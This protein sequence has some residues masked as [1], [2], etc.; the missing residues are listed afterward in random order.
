ML[1]SV[2]QKSDTSGMMITMTDD[3]LVVEDDEANRDF[4]RVLLE[5]EGFLVATV[6][7]G[8]EALDWLVSHPRPSLVLLDLEMPRMDGWEFLQEAD[9]TAT[10]AGI[11]VVILTGRVQRLQ[12]LDWLSKP[13]EPDTLVETLKHHMRVSGQAQSSMPTT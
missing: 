2:H 6:C 1:D 10:L 11:R 7:D 3:V 8:R 5:G 12:V 4:L 13:A 9:R